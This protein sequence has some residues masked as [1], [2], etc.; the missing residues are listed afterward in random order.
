LKIAL[1][2]F[3]IDY[4]IATQKEVTDDSQSEILDHAMKQRIDVVFI[5][6]VGVLTP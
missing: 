5:A 2:R 1:Y 6:A 4:W 3:Q